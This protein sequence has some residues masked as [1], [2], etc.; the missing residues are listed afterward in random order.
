MEKNYIPPGALYIK[1]VA[2]S[3]WYRDRSRLN[4][5]AQR[6]TTQ[7][8]YPTSFPGSFGKLKRG[9]PLEN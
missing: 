2:V 3:Q 8:A 1:L 7:I 9:E 5:D 6:L 4:I